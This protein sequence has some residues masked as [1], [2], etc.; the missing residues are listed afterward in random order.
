MKE[1]RLIDLETKFSH[2]EKAIEVLQQ[3][4]YEQHRK[5]EE[6]EA[7]LARLTSRFDAVD[8]DAQNIGPTNEKPPH[9]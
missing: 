3:V 9:Y 6:L 2:Q 4:T 5:I 7:K 8:T 1:E